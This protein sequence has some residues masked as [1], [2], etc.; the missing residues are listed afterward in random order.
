MAFNAVL[1]MI[2]EIDIG[3]DNH[4]NFY[5]CQVFLHTFHS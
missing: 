4:F 1:R 5:I 3:T 2:T